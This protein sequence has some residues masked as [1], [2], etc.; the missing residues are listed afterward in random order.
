MSLNMKHRS[1]LCC[2]DRVSLPLK[3][4]LNTQKLLLNQTWTQN[5][6]QE[7]KGL[8][9]QIPSKHFRA[10]MPAKGISHTVKL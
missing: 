5:S 7:K 4:K 8:A 10:K 2:F 6:K 9:K 1:C 3:K